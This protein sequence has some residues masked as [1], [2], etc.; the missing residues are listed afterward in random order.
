MVRSIDERKSGEAFDF[1]Q[2]DD[3]RGPAVIINLSD[4]RGRTADAK[5]RATEKIKRRAARKALEKLDQAVAKAHM[6][7][8]YM[9]KDDYR[10]LCAV[11]G[12]N[13]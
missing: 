10:Y 1:S 12:W 3:S 9:T 4:W 6:E 7:T 11:R 8:G 2:I 5:K 13:A